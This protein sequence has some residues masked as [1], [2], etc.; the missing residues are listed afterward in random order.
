MRPLALVL[1]LALTLGAWPPQAAPADA[2]PSF[3]RL[4][5]EASARFAPPQGFEDMAVPLID[6]FPFDRAL[7]DPAGTLQVLYAVRPI[8]RMEIDYDDPHSSAPNPNHIFPLVFD[9]L[10]GMLSAGGHTPSRQFEDRQARKYFNADLAS[11]ATFDLDRAVSAEFR[12]GFL[13]GAHKNQKA[14]LYTLF[15]YND[16]QLAK[17]QI[18]ALLATLAFFPEGS[19]AEPESG[20]P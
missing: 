8:A 7:R 19:A 6:R 1:F 10:V 15:L 16:P 14:D 12:F 11:A 17:A 3:D 18:D 13:V 20:K 4:L 5:V 9:S 2:P